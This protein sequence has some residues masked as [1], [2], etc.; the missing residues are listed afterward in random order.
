M[1]K[2]ILF[3]L[4]GTLLPF[5]PKAFINAYFGGLA[6]KMEPYGYEPQKLT[7]AIWTGVHAM[8]RNDTDKL[9]EQIWWE[10]FEE[11][12]GERVSQDKHIFT[13]YYEKDFAKVQKV[14]GFNPDASRT[15]YDLK[16]KGYRVT[17]A[18]NPVFPSVATEQRIKWAGLLPTDFAIYTT[19]ENSHRCKP[20]LEYYKE[21]LDKLERR[22]EECLM[23]GNDVSEDMVARE[24]G[25]KV[26]L[27]TDCLINSKKKDIS[28]YPQGGFKELSDYIENL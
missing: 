22:P 2:D 4:D 3:D 14:C 25:M 5:E 21:I 26:F 20:K 9:N 6:E 24:M 23:V 7:D 16:D 12:F 15:V 19:Y 27:L 18:T 13:E 17:L 28:E 1:I 8:V 10:T 11:I